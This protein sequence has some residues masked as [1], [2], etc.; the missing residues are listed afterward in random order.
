MKLFYFIFIF[1]L[2]GSVWAGVDS[3]GGGPSVVRFN[4]N[5]EI[6]DAKS[7]D[8]FE[9]PINFQLTIPEQAGTT[10]EIVL[11]TVERVKQRN[12]FVGLELE[13]N[14]K[15]IE[16]KWVFLPAGVVMAPGVDLG[17]S[18]MALIPTG[19]QLFYAGY[20]QENGVLRVSLDIY[21]KLSPTHQAA[22]KIHE[23]F[24]RMARYF[25]YTTNSLSTRQ[26]T[27][28]VFST[29]DLQELNDEFIQK[30]IWRYLWP[31]PMYGFMA[32]TPLFL[33]NDESDFYFK[34][35]EEDQSVQ[36]TLQVEC[37]DGLGN[38]K[39]VTQ[40]KGGG[41]Y[42]LKV[43]AMSPRTGK[44]C[45]GF[46]MYF[47]GPNGGHHLKPVEVRYGVQLVHTYAPVAE[48]FSGSKQLPIYWK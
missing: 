1:I 20:Y 30:F 46:Q 39:P 27:A 10:E 44:L 13:D 28:Y 47:S 12:I 16:K 7:L 19:Y 38:P 2:S 11:R 32:E 31:H 40:T 36:T 6:V 24:Y 3:S 26:M 8:L 23:A 21:Q 35:L 45:R 48:K 22:L 5:G 43:P 33:Q 17:D 25:S 41:T 29:T 14:L 4:S 9:G 18:Y 34:V 37:L 42:E 15:E